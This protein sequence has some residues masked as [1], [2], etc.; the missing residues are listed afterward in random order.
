MDAAALDLTPRGTASIEVLVNGPIQTNSYVVIS[1]GECLIIDPAWE[2]ENLVVHIRAEHP[3]VHVLGSVCTHGHAD[4]VG[5]VAGVRAAVGADALY[6][7]CVKDATVPHANIEEQR[8]MWGIETPD[9]GEPTRLL[10]EGDT[11]EL[12]DI[13]LQVIEAPGHTPGG[14]VLFAATEQGN[15]AFVGDTLFPGSHGRTDLSGGDEA[16]IL[17][18]LSKLARLLP[19][20]TV[21]LTGHGDSTTVARELMQNPFMQM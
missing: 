13:C 18:S 15:I 6:E 19:P 14:I 16:A 11:I 21:C 1:S 17:R 7:L 3:G 2:G 9:P 8:V 10:A 5:G 12:G 20:D 4:H